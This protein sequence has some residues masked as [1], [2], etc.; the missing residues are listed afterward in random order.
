MKTNLFFIKALLI[1]FLVSA[2]S[3][4]DNTTAIQDFA[5]AFENPSA[6]FLSTDVD[7]DIT[8]VFAPAATTDGTLTISYI[9]NNASYGTEGDFTTLPSGGSGTIILPFSAGD[10]Q[11]SMTVNK[12][13]NPI[14][15][16]TKSINFSIDSVSLTN[17]FI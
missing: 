6:S 14:E 8:I 12:L 3:E 2:C 4:D 9:L 17:G 10:S 11:V 7:K 15:G 1:L 5:V 13:Q 16:D